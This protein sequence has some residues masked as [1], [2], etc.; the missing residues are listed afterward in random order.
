MVLG[1]LYALVFVV[2]AHNAACFNITHFYA[3]G[4]DAHTKE[5]MNIIRAASTDKIP[6]L[7]KVTIGINWL[8]EPATNYYI[9]KDNLYWIDWTTRHGPDGEYDYYYFCDGDKDI[10]NKRN[11]KIMRHFE[12][13][14]SYVALPKQNFDSEVRAEVKER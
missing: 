6:A 4:F 10:I 1:A 2:L 8:F 11:L 12:I 9:F 7:R 14:E 13:F 5:V 3:W